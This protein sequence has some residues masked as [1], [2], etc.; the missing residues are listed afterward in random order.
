MTAPDADEMRA[1][2]WAWVEEQGC[3]TDGAWSAWQ[4]AWDLRYRQGFAAGMEAAAKMV[5]AQEFAKIVPDDIRND[6]E[7]QMMTDI[8]QWT[9]Y[10]TVAAA[11]RSAK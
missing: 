11:I 1:A 9:V 5:D 3:D 8:M 6:P 10:G 7:A 4:A 2:F